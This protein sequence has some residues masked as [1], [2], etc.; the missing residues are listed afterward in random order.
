MTISASERDELRALARDSFGERGAQLLMAGLEGADLAGME[1]RL[2]LR[3]ELVRA[4]LRGEM[5]ELRNDFTGLRGEFS[6]LRGEFGL[7]RGEFG[8]LRGEFGELRGEFGELRGEF[9][10]LKGFVGREIGALRA[11]IGKQHRLNF[12]A[13]VTAIVGIASLVYSAYQLG[14]G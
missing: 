7:L 3:G 11:E 8:E 13:M 14:A 6:E 10:E 4:E 5:A 9:G 1:E 2:T 12:F